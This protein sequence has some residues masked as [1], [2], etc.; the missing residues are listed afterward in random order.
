VWTVHASQEYSTASLESE[1]SAV[2][3]RLLKAFLGLCNARSAT[4]TATHVHRWRYARALTREASPYRFEEN[5]G[6]AGDI[7]GGARVESAYLSGVALAGEVLR[8][9]AAEGAGPRIAKQ[10]GGEGV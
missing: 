7:F 9:L 2:S 5:L 3:E 10:A 6:F 1:A 4:V 8:G